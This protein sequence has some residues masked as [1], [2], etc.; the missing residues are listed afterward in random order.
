MYLDHTEHND[1]PQM[2]SSD[3]FLERDRQ[4]GMIL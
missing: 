2:T 3:K 4:Q 1:V